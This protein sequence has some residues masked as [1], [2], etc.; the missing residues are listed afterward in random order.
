MLQCIEKGREGSNYWWYQK[1]LCYDSLQRFKN[2]FYRFWQR[3]RSARCRFFQG[4]T[5]QPPRMHHT[6]KQRYMKSSTNS[7]ANHCTRCWI[8]YLDSD[9]TPSGSSSSTTPNKN[10]GCKKKKRC[11]KRASTP[12]LP[13]PTSTHDRSQGFA[14]GGLEKEPQ[15]SLVSHPILLFF[16]KSC[17]WTGALNIFSSIARFI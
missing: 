11:V 1:L 2:E 17:P 12:S 15:S 13:G 16:F 8:P 9:R 10:A 5:S 4:D 7:L 3:L 6:S 14:R